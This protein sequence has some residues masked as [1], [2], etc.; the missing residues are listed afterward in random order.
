MGGRLSHV[1]KLSEIS[2]RTDYFQATKS[3]FQKPGMLII[4]YLKGSL[5]K[6][7]QIHENVKDFQA[8]K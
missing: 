7:K 5:K 6:A 1:T 3:A 2:L 8:G 4:I